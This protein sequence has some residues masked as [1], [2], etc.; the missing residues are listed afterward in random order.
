MVIVRLL[1]D[2]KPFQLFVVLTFL[3]PAKKVYALPND[4][5]QTEDSVIVPIEL[6]PFIPKGYTFLYA[7][8]GD[9]NL[10]GIADVLLVIEFNNQAVVNDSTEAE[11]DQGTRPL[12]LLTRDSLN[13]L[14]LVM[15][16]DNTVLCKECG[17][18]WGDPFQGIAV[19]NGYFSVEHYG[20]SNWRWT[21]IITYKFN[22]Q[23]GD[24]FLHKVGSESYS[25]FDPDKVETEIK[26]VND[27]GVI[28]LEDYNIY[29]ED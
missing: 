13:Q 26:T 12:L 9:L 11:M 24:W 22:K 7:Q 15:R 3:C 17:G 28:K 1:F 4:C 23:K 5:M 25:I 21:S 2:M 10:D 29:T 14:N 19:K 20:G 6:K 27:F 18:V 8:N 16:N